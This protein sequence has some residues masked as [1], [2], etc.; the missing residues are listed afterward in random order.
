MSGSFDAI[1]WAA[2]ERMGVVNRVLARV[3]P[4][5]QT[6]NELLRTSQRA[7]ELAQRAEKVH[8]IARPDDR[9]EFCLL[10]LRVHAQFD[11]HP[12][13]RSFLDRAAQEPTAFDELL[14]QDAAFW[15]NVSQTLN[16]TE[17]ERK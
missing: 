11:E 16:T 14:S 12:R 2:F 1:T 5:A 17:E 4:G 15:Q 7:D 8:Q 10:G 9:V 13:V 3:Q 6:M